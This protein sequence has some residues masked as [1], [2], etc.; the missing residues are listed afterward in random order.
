MPGQYTIKIFIFISIPLIV[1]IFSSNLFSFLDKD[2]RYRNKSIDG[3]RFFLSIFVVFHHMIYSYNWLHGYGWSKGD[4]YFNKKLGR[5]AVALFFILSAHLMTRRNLTKPSDIIKLYINR[6][7][8][9]IPMAY[10]SSF[11]CLITAVIFGKNIDY[12]SLIEKLFYWFDGGVTEYKPDI[13]SFSPAS[14]VNAG[15]MWTLS[16]EWFLYFSLPII[17]IARDKI[18][19]LLVS[20]FI[21]LIAIFYISQNQ[22]YVACYILCFSLG[23]TVSDIFHKI[24]IDN[25]ISSIIILLCIIAVFMSDDDPVSINNIIME[26]IILYHVCIGGDIFGILKLKGAVRLGEVSYSM[27]VLHGIFLFYINKISIYYNINHPCYLLILLFGIIVMCLTS[28]ATF[29]FIEKPGIKLGK[30]I[31]RKYI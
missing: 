27:Y 18:N 4:Y 26:F 29:F 28:C 20:Q 19:G 9:I 30:N 31:A 25:T 2:E 24:K 5:F 13:N 3:L 10:V 15:V 14:H 16:W 11:L 1:F 6:I 21:A 8:R 7:F 12:G 17:Y 22:Y 23:M